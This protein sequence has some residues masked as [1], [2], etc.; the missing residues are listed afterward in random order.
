MA[1]EAS[2][3]GQAACAGPTPASWAEL[4]RPSPTAAAAGKPLSNRAIR[5]ALK[6]QGTSGAAA[7]V[8]ARDS[9]PGSAASGDRGIS[10]VPEPVAASD[11]APDPLGSGATVAG[12]GP[13]PPETPAAAGAVNADVSFLRTGASHDLAGTAAPRH[14]TDGGGST[15]TRAGASS[16]G[17]GG[18][19]NGL[20]QLAASSP[21]AGQQAAEGAEVA[22]R[23]RKSKAMLSL[24]GM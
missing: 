13:T 17:G 4:L 9:A 19:G 12:A 22:D 23:R 5:A 6:Q 3:G 2:E 1:N 18:D 7:A 16:G 8:T 21:R 14:A 10:V 11:I 24:L 15:A 20:Q